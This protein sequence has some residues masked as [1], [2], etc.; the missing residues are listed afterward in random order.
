MHAPGASSSIDVRHKSNAGTLARQNELRA[1]P[2]DPERSIG[3]FCRCTIGGNPR[4]NRLEPCRMR[5]FENPQ[6]FPAELSAEFRQRARYD[7]QTGGRANPASR[8]EVRV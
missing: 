1:L 6:M 2:A 5:R 8:S 3:R 4:L 7:A